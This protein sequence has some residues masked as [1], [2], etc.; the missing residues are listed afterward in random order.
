[1][2]SI[3]YLAGG[4]VDAR[5]RLLYE[6]LSAWSGGPVLHLVPTSGRVIELESDPR[7]WLKRKQDTL[8][9]VIHRIFEDNI[10]FR[11]FRDCR[12]IDDGVRSL[13]AR[14]ALEKRMSQP[15]GLL[16]FNRLMID[17]EIGFPGIFRAV[18][19]F[20]SQ[21]V[22]NNYQDRF[23]NDLGGKIMR[24]E[25]KGVERG[26][27]AYP[28]QSDLAWL[29]GDYEEI[30]KEINAYDEDDVLS[31][32]RDFLGQTA[33]PYPVKGTEVIIFDGFIH[34]S[35]IEEDILQRLFGQAKE[36]WW[37]L[38]FNGASPDPVGDF[39]SASSLASLSP[40]TLN[41]PPTPSKRGTNHPT[42][43][44]SLTQTSS[45]IIPDN[46]L[47]ERNLKKRGME[48]CR[49]F[50]PMAEFM[51]KLEADGFET[52]TEK[53]GDAVFRNPAA[54]GLYL[55]NL[56]RDVEGGSLRIKYFPTR[57]HEVRAIAK[58]IKR[59]IREDRLDASKDLGKIRIIFPDLNEYASLISEI[60]KEYGIPLSLTRGLPLFSH[61]LSNLFL[62][63]FKLPLDHFKREDVFRFFSS[64]L[65]RGKGAGLPYI[66]HEEALA[67]LKDY[68][69]P[70]DDLCSIEALMER[71][72]RQYTPVM[73][74]L[75]FET[76]HCEESLAPTFLDI[77][78]IDRV[79][80]TCGLHTLGGEGDA[81]DTA[82]SAVRDSYLQKL[83]K[84]PEQQERSSLQWEYYSF[85]L[86]QSLLAGAL[87]PFKLLTG[88]DN[89][90]GIESALSNV[91]DAFGFPGNIAEAAELMVS[92]DR[93][94][95]RKSMRRDLNA[96]A[97]LK[98]LASSS[99]SEL[100]IDNQLFKIKSGHEL[101][102]ALHRIFRKRI[103]DA[104]LMDEQDPNVIRVSQ[105]LEIRGRSFDYVFAGGLTDKSFPLKEQS[106]F[107][108]PEPSKSVFRVPDNIDMSRHLFSHLLRNYRNGLYLSCPSYTDGKEIRPSNVFTD[109]ESMMA[110]GQTRGST[111][112]EEIFKWEESPCLASGQEM[113]DSSIVKTGSLDLP[114]ETPF[115]LNDII[116]TDKSLLE[117]VIRGVR[118]MA[119]RWA[120]NGLFEYD[121]LVGNADKFKEYLKAKKDVFSAS[122][123]EALANCPM[124]YLFERIYGLK[125]M[126]EITPDATPMAMGEHIHGVLRLFF[127]R[128]KDAEVNV[129]SLGIDKAFSMAGEAA[130]EYFK[131]NPFIER[132]EFFEHQKNEFLDG[133]DN[134][135]PGASPSVREG[136]FALLLRFEDN[137]FH[138][139]VPEGIEYEFG[140]RG[141]ASP[142]L[143]KVRLRGFID[144]FDRDLN[145]RKKFYIYDYKTGA[146]PPTALIKQGLSFQLP[147]YIKALKTFIKG[148]KITASL[149]SLKRD[150]LLKG[151]PMGQ[152]L[153]DR[154][155]E[156]GGLDLSGVTALDRYADQLMELIDA[157]L[158]HH[159]ADMVKCEYC[160]FKYV[161]HRDER[162]MD[163]LVDSK[164]GYGIYSGVKNLETWKEVDNFRKEWKK[165]LESMEKAFNLKTACGRGNHFESVLDFERKIQG[166]R[167]SLP[168]NDEHLDE[169]LGEIKAF[170]IR[171]EEE[172]LN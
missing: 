1:M 43:W 125:T 20:F 83:S 60:F 5:Q 135:A 62:L 71:F 165:T 157:G 89:P 152:N 22:R 15:E 151:A 34:L 168:F 121:G 166:N 153:C 64:E 38:D 167:C 32:V 10:R 56:V 113:L 73:P 147:V 171:W 106:D 139:R 21:L 127:R 79:A 49:I 90:H 163:Y 74:E 170:K 120:L 98:S 124:R 85:V 141:Q 37:T 11:Q 6:K 12:P 158:F 118:A 119:S 31:S 155:R 95:D 55:D 51:D 82:I 92:P 91:L 76:L 84:R 72:D 26:E 144:R 54:E 47:P 3:H 80:Q 19:S 50:R 57:T 53:C 162:R 134:P 59:I 16:Y 97:M 110:A 136:V 68:L 13:I 131:A 29:F 126:E 69:L 164:K 149:Y 100:A 169:L 116:I 107:I 9:G 117:G 77:E 140:F 101:L 75:S 28:L 4:N 112:I 159:S 99:A 145:D 105:W 42:S 52:V 70:G 30:K 78:F 146:P 129:A 25:E 17:H 94:F 96:W 172:G 148:E 8:T 65:I 160:D 44:R 36:V 66:N 102:S 115:P 123:L 128:L 88:Q 23:A 150:A 109:M 2:T 40:Q 7:F 33:S 161:C 45:E 24:A 14:K 111:E 132:I 46:T 137:N 138:E 48:A 154:S 27:D 142:C 67:L 114:S 93:P 39:K 122:H 35:I 58:E 156:A 108:I 86:Q 103:E 130:D 41:P 81:L 104:Y 87:S 133:L 61:P 63:L 143:G 18:S